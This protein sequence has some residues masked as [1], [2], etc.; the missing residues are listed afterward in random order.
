[1]LMGAEENGGELASGKGV[2]GG[3]ARAVLDVEASHVD[4]LSFPVGLY[5]F[6][7]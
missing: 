1:V 3:E 5:Y 7:G 2:S 6:G 4:V